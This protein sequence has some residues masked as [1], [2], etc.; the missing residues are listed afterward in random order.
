MP[1]NVSEALNSDTALTLVV[2][3]TTGTYVDGVW[4]TNAPSTFKMLASP[5]QPTPKQLE[6]LPEGERSKNVMLFI[7]NKRV[8]TV[9]EK[10]GTPPDIINFDSKKFR[11]V[12]LGNWITFGH[13]H[14]LA[15]EDQ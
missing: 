12:A 15:A 4:T 7:C 2:D 5:Q 6:I 14:A 8:K 9:D 11:V 10:A 3:R 1:I 13:V